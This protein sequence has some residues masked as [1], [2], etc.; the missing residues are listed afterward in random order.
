MYLFIYLGFLRGEG[1]IWGRIA[2]WTKT[3]SDNKDYDQ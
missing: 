2:S 3:D 1:A